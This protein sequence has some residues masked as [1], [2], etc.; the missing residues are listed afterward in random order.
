MTDFETFISFND[1]KKKDIAAFLGVSNAFITQL[2]AGERALPK[3]KYALIKANENWNT[4]MLEREYPEAPQKENKQEEP[5][6]VQSLLDLLKTK[7]EQITK[8]LDIIA[9]MQ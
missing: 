2:C 5:L 4:S 8:L 7:D 9:S 3:E 1:I 6:L